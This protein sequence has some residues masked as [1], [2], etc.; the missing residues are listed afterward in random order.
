MSDAT[1]E[2]YRKRRQQRLDAKSEEQRK[3]IN[4]YHER[5]WKRLEAR[6]VPFAERVA[7]LAKH[8]SIGKSESGAESGLEGD[9]NLRSS[10]KNVIIYKSDSADNDWIV[11]NGVEGHFR[12]V[13][14]TDFFLTRDGKVGLGE[15]SGKTMDEMFKA[16]E[17]LR[18]AIHEHKIHV[19]RQKEWYSETGC[20]QTAIEVDGVGY[21]ICPSQ[22][23]PEMGWGL[24]SIEGAPVDG[25]YET[26]VERTTKLIRDIVAEE[27]LTTRCSSETAIKILREG[28]FKSQFETGVSTGILDP[29]HRSTV[30]CIA[31]G[32]PEDI[33]PKLRPIYGVYGDND[34]TKNYGS[35]KFILKDAVKPRTTVTACDSYMAEKRGISA[36]PATNIQPYSI[37]KVQEKRTKDQ[38]VKHIG[39]VE[40]QIHGG[41]TIGDISRVQIKSTHPAKD[42]VKELCQRAGIYLEEV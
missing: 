13:N 7:I 8:S 29:E 22:R 17:S 41:V 26:E 27:S 38:Y 21:K 6:G 32:V 36:S 30:E 28:R 2:A 16:K 42:D 5:V 20:L 14:G 18:A 12:N 1:V 24:C 4:D 35:V 34:M 9:I 10:W 37:Q 40:A 25:D 19:E 15:Y 33:E 3:I 11:V 31:M 39:Y 23:S